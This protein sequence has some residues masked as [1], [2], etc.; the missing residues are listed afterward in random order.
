MQMEQCE[1]PAEDKMAMPTMSRSRRF[2]AA[3]FNPDTGAMTA[4]MKAHG[5]NGNSGGI[6]A[7]H[8]PGVAVTCCILTF[9]SIFAQARRTR[10]IKG[11]RPHLAIAGK[12]S[13]TT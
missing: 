9:R 7:G 6:A 12:Y 4:R 8:R 10:W 13:D 5:G 1:I 3:G 11:I 2:A